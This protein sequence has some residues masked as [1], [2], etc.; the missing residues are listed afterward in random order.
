MG[1]YQNAAFFQLH[2]IIDKSNAEIPKIKLLH[3]L[4]TNN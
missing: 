1:Y 2:T 3:R 4:I